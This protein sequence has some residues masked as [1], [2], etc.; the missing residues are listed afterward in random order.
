MRSLMDSIKQRIPG[1]YNTIGVNCSPLAL[2]LL[3]TITL[4]FV[5]DWESPLFA[6]LPAL[7]LLFELETEFCELPALW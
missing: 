7:E 6:L 2:Q 4:M 1:K 3:Q 5:S